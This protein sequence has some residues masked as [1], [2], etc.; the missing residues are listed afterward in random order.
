MFLQ[1][2]EAPSAPRK[3]INDCARAVRKTFSQMVEAASSIRKNDLNTHF[4][5]PQ[6]VWIHASNA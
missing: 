6:N 4:R 5:A 3:N 2:I 1:I